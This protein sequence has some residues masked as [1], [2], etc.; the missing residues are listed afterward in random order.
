MKNF[1]PFLILLFISIGN[2]K[3]Q[4]V[5]PS[6]LS[7]INLSTNFA[8]ITWQENG[9]ATDWDIEWG[10]AGFTPGTGIM[11]SVTMN[12]YGLVGLLP[13]TS[14]CFYV[15]SN[16][17]PANFCS[18]VGPYCFSTTCNAP[19][20]LNAVNVTATSVDLS[21]TENGTATA[22][23]IEFGPDG[24]VPTGTPTI[25]MTLINPHILTGLLPATSYCYYVRSY[26]GPAN[27]S[28]WVGP[29][30]FTTA[31]N[32]NPSYTYVDNGNGNFSFT[33][34]SS[35]GA[36][37]SHWAFGDGNTS[38]AMSPS[39]QFSANGNYLVVLSTNDTAS[40]VPCSDSY[41]DTIN[42]T[43]V[44]N[45]AAC[46]A[47]YSVFP[48]ING[49]GIYNSSTGNN[50]NYMW[51]FGDGSVSTLQNPTHTYSTAGPFYLCLTV[52]DGAGGCIDQF[53]DSIGQNGVV[54]NKAGFTISVISPIVTGVDS[55][56][57]GTSVI[58]IYPNPATD[59]LN[60]IHQNQTIKEISIA[61]VTGKIWKN[62]TGNT[63]VIN[64]SDIPAG[65]YF[66]QIINTEKT[67][68][69]K[70]VVQ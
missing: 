63:R 43:G 66:V 31:C 52:N 67:I 39:H 20:F 1:I 3:A 5:D 58:N 14:Y 41:I 46:I 16:C 70:I 64:I 24:F 62:I 35:G 69:E 55:E 29:Y 54:F 23:D 8:E 34:T 13:A 2:L 21:W 26:C 44:T 18:W 12:P 36:S 28:S 11:A 59:E 37:Q 7:A 65:I 38:T 53:C 42:V 49:I 60:I 61:D 48:D 56:I 30:C 25:A 51:T 47:G 27:F 15:R 9:T 50:L 19:S 32:T 22:W 17:G 4:C 33:N 6:F 57:N 10:A 68:V 45:P 40:S